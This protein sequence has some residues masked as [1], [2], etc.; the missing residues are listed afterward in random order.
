MILSILT[1]ALTIDSLNHLIPVLMV[2]VSHE[3]RTKWDT[4]Q[5][6]IWN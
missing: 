5:I 3:R 6:L 2:S 4:F 1:V